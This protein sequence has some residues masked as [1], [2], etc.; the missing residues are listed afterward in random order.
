[1][2][3]EHLDAGNRLAGAGFEQY[4]QGGGGG[5]LTVPLGTV[6]FA[7]TQNNFYVASIGLTFPLSPRGNKKPPR[8]EGAGRTAS[9]AIRAFLRGTAGLKNGSGRRSI[10][11]ALVPQHQALAEGGRVSPQ[12]PGS[13]GGSIFQRAVDIIKLL[14]SQN[15]ALTTESGRRQCGLRISDR[16]GEGTAGG[17]ADE[18][19]P[20]LRRRAAWL[21]RLK[22]HL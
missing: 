8:C 9:T 10:K 3:S 17:G 22:T 19:L 21:E 1:M 15:A 12:D 11:P 7:Q 14:N 13:G 18:L 2:P 16:S 5:S 20:K 4:A 6:G